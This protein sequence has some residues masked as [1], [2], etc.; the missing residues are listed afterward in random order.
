[1]L[2]RWESESDPVRSFEFGAIA[3]LPGGNGSLRMMRGKDIGRPR[4]ATRSGRP[5]E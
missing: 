1:M 3:F 5:F 2:H 4:I